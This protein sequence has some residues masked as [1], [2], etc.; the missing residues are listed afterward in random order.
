[1]TNWPS[2][3]LTCV[4]TL[5]TCARMSTLFSAL[6]VPVASSTTSTSFASARTLLTLI[7]PPE[8]GATPGAG[9]TPEAAP[10]ALG[11]GSSVHAVAPIAN[12]SVA[13]Q[14]IRLLFMQIQ[15]ARR[16]AAPCRFVTARH[17][18]Q[19]ARRVQRTKTR[20][21]AFVYAGSVSRPPQ[22][23]PVEPNPA[24]PR[25]E[26]PNSSTSRKLACTTGTI[27]SCAMRSSGCT[28]KAAVPRFQQLTISGPW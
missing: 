17:S 24:A 20:S 8:P 4:I 27:T 11:A 22:A 13:A 5:L 23:R 7:G 6:T 10:A 21:R 9:A 2:R 1:M 14:P 28:V 12:A 3:M 25:S 26:A 19:S 18:R 16:K 15:W